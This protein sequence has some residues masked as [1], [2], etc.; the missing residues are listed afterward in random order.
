MFE[1]HPCG[2]CRHFQSSVFAQKDL[3]HLAE[4]RL[5]S[6][7]TRILDDFP[8]YYVKSQTNVITSPDSKMELEMDIVH[9]RLKD[10]DR[11]STG[12]VGKRH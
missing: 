5:A 10:V 8:K 3:V 12:S 2:S 4:K 7:S 9:E 11:T 6:Y 1:V